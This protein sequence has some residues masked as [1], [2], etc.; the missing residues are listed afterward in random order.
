[1]SDVVRF[2]EAPFNGELL[3]VDPQARGV[4]IDVRPAVQEDFAFI[5]ALQKQESDKVG[6][7]YEQAIRKRI[8]QGNIIIAEHDA[9]PVGYCLGVDRYQKR[10]E[11]GIIYQMAVLPE[12]RRC[13]VA[14]VLLQAQ[15]DKS[16]YGCRLYCCWC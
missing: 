5:D 13:N 7:M 11:L 4:D 15:F 6:F 14:A 10:S 1:M 16:A 12:Y 3:K 2:E 9:I 8:E